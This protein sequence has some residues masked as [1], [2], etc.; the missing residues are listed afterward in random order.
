ARLELDSSVRLD[1]EQRVEADRAAGER[2]DRHAD[3]ARL[4]ALALA[5]DRRLLL[6]PLEQLAPLVERFAHEGARDVRLFAG[7]QR[8]TEG[9]LAR[10]RVD[11]AQ[12][13]L[14]DAELSRG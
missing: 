5:A 8:R 9:R 2:A 10:R 4:G 7:R 13:H 11:L 1:D 6:L 12:L 3:S 14:V